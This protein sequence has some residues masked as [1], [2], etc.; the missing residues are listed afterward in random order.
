MAWRPFEL[1][2]QFQT[3]NDILI[4]RLIR[5]RQ[6]I[7]KLSASAYHLNEAVA[8]IMVMLVGFQVL[9]QLV[10][11]VGKQGRLN[12]GRPAVFVMTLKGLLYFAFVF[13]FHFFFC[14]LY[15]AL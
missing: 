14:Y 6:I 1:T 3:L 9:G 12:A 4:T 11:P 10:N 7:K 5:S 13:I 8:G 15:R 2:A